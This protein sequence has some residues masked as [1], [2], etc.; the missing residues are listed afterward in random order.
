MKHFA[1][2]LAAASISLLLLT[3]P[4]VNAQS[5]EGFLPMF[6]GKTLDSWT[7]DSKIWSVEDGCIVGKT[8]DEGT[9]K[10]TY[11]TFLIWQGGGKFSGGEVSGDFV[12]RF[13]YRLSNPG[14]SGLQYRSRE[15]KDDPGKPYRVHGYQADFDGNNTYSGIM[16]EEGGRGIIAQRGTKSKIGGDHKPKVVET[17]ANDGDLKAKINIADWNSY[18]IIAE[19]FT[20]THKINGEVT[21][22]CVDEDSEKRSG[23]GIIALQAHVGPPMKVEIKNIRIKSVE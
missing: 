11:N 12:I 15:L 14:N 1:L 18:E 21:S 20:L 22:V 3:A 16:Y 17:F 8:D 23:K 13:D 2:S 7:G 9:T 6:D 19:G 10:L 4:R 5:D